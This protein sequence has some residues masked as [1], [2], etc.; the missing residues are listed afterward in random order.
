[1]VISSLSVYVKLTPTLSQKLS[2]HS[3]ELALVAVPERVLILLPLNVLALG[4][5]HVLSFLVKTDIF[6]E[7]MPVVH[8]MKQSSLN[9]LLNKKFIKE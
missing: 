1:M 7:T 6:V 8:V 2:T 4:E 5:V 9:L 3:F